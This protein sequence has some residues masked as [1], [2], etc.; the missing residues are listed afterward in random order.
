MVL[1]PGSRSGPLATASGLMATQGMLQ[2][3]TA[4][5]ERSAAFLAL[6]MAT[7]VPDVVTTATVLPEAVAIPRARK[8]ADRSSIAVKSC[9][10][11]WVAIRPDAVAKGPERLPGQSTS[12][13]NP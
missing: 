1:C 4:I 8:A 13:R 2:L 7:A 3:F 6:G 12:R 10:I 11:P 5:D 9:S